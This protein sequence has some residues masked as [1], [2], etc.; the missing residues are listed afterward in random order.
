MA[1]KDR[2]DFDSL[3]NEAEGLVLAELEA[4][5][6]RL[7]ARI[8]ASGRA[9]AAGAGAARG[10]AS[11][12]AP[13]TCQDCVLDMAAYALNRARPSYRVSL[14]GTFSSSTAEKAGYAREIAQ[15]VREAIEKVRANPSHD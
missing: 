14:M 15:A 11:D 8:P 4:Q 9:G 1:L 7:G 6:A 13:C 5:L 12:G 10:K 3:V 2:Y